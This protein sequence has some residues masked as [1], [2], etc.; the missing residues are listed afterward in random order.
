MRKKGDL[1]NFECDM[2]VGA[3]RGS[4]SIFTIR[5]FYKQFSHTTL[6]RVYKKWCEKGKTSSIQ[7]SCGRK[8]LVD[9]RGQRMGR[10][11]QA[12]RRATLTEIT[13]HS[14]PQGVT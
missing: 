8:C 3:R 12:D 14:Q 5:N 2:V 10:L 4:L 13:A 9:A 7:Q 11:I 6:S 1:S